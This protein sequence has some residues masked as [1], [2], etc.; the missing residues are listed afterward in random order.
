[1][2]WLDCMGAQQE[3]VTVEEGPCRMRMAVNTLFKLLLVFISG[4]GFVFAFITVRSVMSFLS[5]IPSSNVD[6]VQIRG[7][8]TLWAL[9]VNTSLL[10]LFIFQHSAMVTPFFKRAL[11]AA[12]LQVAERSIYVIATSFVLQCVIQYW[13]P[14][15]WISLWHVDT[16]GTVLWTAFTLMHCCAWCIIYIGTIIMDLGEMLGIKQV[17]YSL[18]GLPDPITLKSR[19]LQRLYLHMRHP[20]FIGFCILFWIYPFMSLDRILL[21]G[22]WTL[23]MILAWNVDQSDYEYQCQQLRKKHS[24]LMYY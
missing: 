7:S 15:P 16:S 4:F 24:K 20:S 14:I 1:M 8:T 6:A 18:R 19:D 2:Q 22:L 23:Y 17:Y 12:R 9:T 13:Q 10:C 3:K 21:A 5:I 11:Y